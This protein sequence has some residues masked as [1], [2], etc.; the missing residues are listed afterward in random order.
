MIP[1][2][3][4]P[5]NAV[6]YFTPTFI[7]LSVRDKSFFITTLLK[8][9]SYFYEFLTWTQHVSASKSKLS[10]EKYPFPKHANSEA[11]V[12]KSENLTFNIPCMKIPSHVLLNNITL[13]LRYFPCLTL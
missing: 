6:F 13:R 5:Y 11:V 7:S 10:L 1:T 3:R 9:T 4:V 12:I 2:I 8:I